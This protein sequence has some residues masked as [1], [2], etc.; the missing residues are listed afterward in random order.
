MSII[1]IFDVNQKDLRHKSW[2]VVGVHV[3][4]YKEYTAYSYTIK[5]LLV[6]LIL[7]IAVKNWLA[8]MAGDIRNS[9]CMSH[10]LKI[11]G[12]GMVGNLVLDM[13]K[14]WY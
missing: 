11:F 5:Y 2:Q 1:M 9:L 12:I 7:L 4:D 8:L 14:Q 6:R 10:V 3:V 13:V